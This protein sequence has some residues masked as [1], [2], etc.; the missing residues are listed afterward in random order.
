VIRA[1]FAADPELDFVY[2][3][4]EFIDEHEQVW[5]SSEM[6]PA[7]HLLDEE[8]KLPRL[9]GRERWVEQAI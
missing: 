2:T 1:M 8:Q 9:R 3:D 6:L 5:E 7:L 4:I